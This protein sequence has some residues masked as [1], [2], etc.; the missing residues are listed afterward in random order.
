MSGTSLGG[1][2]AF[3]A[4]LLGGQQQG[5]IVEQ[6]AGAAELVCELRSVGGDAVELRQQDQAAEGQVIPYG[7]AGRCGL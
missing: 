7:F 3:Q 4:E 2:L 5:C 6:F 1:L